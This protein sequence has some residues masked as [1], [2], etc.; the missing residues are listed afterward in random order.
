MRF[1]VLGVYCKIYISVS[2]VGSEKKRMRFGV[3]LE[4]ENTVSRYLMRR[5]SQFLH[6]LGVV[7]CKL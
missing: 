2:E 6:V 5:I 7:Y 1:G 3:L 4:R